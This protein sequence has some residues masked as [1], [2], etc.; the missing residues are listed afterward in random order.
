MDAGPQIAKAA[1]RK[2]ATE[3]LVFDCANENPMAMAILRAMSDA[4]SRAILSSI[5]AAGKSIEDV[6][7][8][9]GVPIST[10]YRRV[11]ELTEYGLV[12]VERIVVGPTGKKCSI[13]RSTLRGAKIDVEYDRVKVVG[14]PNEMVPDVM[15]R[16]W[17]AAESHGQ[18]E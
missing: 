4:T 14:L 12:I 8:T 17:R 1:L 11:H 2:P 9:I 3:V 18:S 16:L 6:A 13:Y 15:F 7:E 10:T 5:V